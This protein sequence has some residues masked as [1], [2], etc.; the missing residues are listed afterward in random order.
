MKIVVINSSF[1]KNGNTG[2]IIKLMED[3]MRKAAEREKIN[4]E[5]DHLT[6]GEINLSVCRGCRVCFDKG[7][8]Q[9]PLKDNL[10]EVRNKLLAADGIVLGSPVYVEDVNG[11]LKNMI[12]RLAFHSH[13]PAFL[14][15]NALIFTTSAGGSTNHA[16]KTMQ[17]ALSSWG[18]YISAKRRF[19]MGALMKAEDAERNFNETVGRLA[20]KF[21]KS[22]HEN[23]PYNPSFYSYIIF[24]I[25]QKFWQKKTHPDN[26]F[27][28][29][30]WKKNGWL[31]PH[32]DYYIAH[33]PAPIKSKAA[34]AIGGFV[35]L[36]FI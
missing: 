18:F 16:L 28:Y 3:S 33:K 12:D 27:D 32:R 23:Q 24:K 35:A 1:R 17:N 4:I 9:C 15:K 21:L 10:I 22:I 2:L 14:G 31:D 7:E 20:V 30:F 34:R 8:E 26:K 13:R 5:F 29:E 25:Q 6:L 36:F 11:P 19:R